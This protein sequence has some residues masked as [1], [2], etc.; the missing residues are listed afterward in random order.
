MFPRNIFVPIL[1]KIASP[2]FDSNR[3]GI[4][5]ESVAIIK[6]NKHNITDIQT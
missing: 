4:I 6:T 2:I 5:Y 1:Y 3:G